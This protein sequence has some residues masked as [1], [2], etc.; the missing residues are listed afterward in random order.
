[1]ETDRLRQFLVVARVGTVRAAAE[2]L[3]MTP[4]GL[5]K[6]LDTLEREL[7]R[8][9]LFRKDGRNLVLTDLGRSIEGSA[10]TFLKSLDR[11]LSPPSQS[12]VAKLKIVTF[13]VFSTYFMSQF[14]ASQKEDLALICSEGIP[15]QIEKMIQSGQA[16]IG[17]TYEPIAMSGIEFLK[18]CRIRMGV[19]GRPRL[20][21]QGD[22]GSLPFAAPRLTI[23]H[24][25]SGVKGLD[26]WPDDKVPRVIRYEVDLMETALGLARQGKAVVHV[27]SFVASLHNKLVKKECELEEIE[28]NQKPVYRWVYLVQRS[29]SSESSFSK[30]LAQSIRSLAS[31]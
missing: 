21:K 28:T 9:S 12:E 1:M 25:P 13:E 7:G 30:R 6:S 5:S 19:Y 17:I 11:F 16:D 24:T 18:V 10:D 26:G 8:G 2:I 4:G 23:D 15:G 22:L 14:I 3:H 20:F 29:G 27:P 31:S